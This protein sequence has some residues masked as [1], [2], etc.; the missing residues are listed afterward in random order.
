MKKFL[1]TAFFIILAIVCAFAWILSGS[2]YRTGVAQDKFF[3][4]AK[5]RADKIYAEQ[6]AET[7]TDSSDMQITVEPI[8]PD[9]P[10]DER[11]SVVL[12]FGGDMNLDSKYSDV[13][14]AGDFAPELLSQMRDADIFMHGNVFVF[15]DGGIPAD[16][17]YVFR[18]DTSKISLLEDIGTDVVSLANNHS[19]DYGT[20]G[21]KITTGV[22]DNANIAYVGA[23][24]D[25]TS[26]SEPHYIDVGGIRIAFTA[27]M[28]SERYPKTPEAGENHAGVVKMYDIEGYLEVIREAKKN[29]DFVVAYAH[30]G[31]ENNR[32]LESEQ[33]EGAKA[34]VD[35]GADIVVGA[36]AHV[37]QTADVYNGKPIFYGLGD[38]YGEGGLAKITIEADDTINAKFIP[39]ENVNGVVTPLTGEK[40]NSTIAELDFISHTNV[41][42]DGTISE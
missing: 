27:A 30:W 18:A 41:L 20:D 2:G 9:D 15:A 17:A 13:D 22:L 26:A 31:A 40:Y 16:K 32:W 28:R 6:T 36:H 37:L 1:P 25:G 12:V 24:L 42:P 14:D 10:A 3:D 38:L 33:I 21:L 5:D 23:G 7:T 19:F 39:F 8:T 29:A 34:M 11:E 4:I 35:A